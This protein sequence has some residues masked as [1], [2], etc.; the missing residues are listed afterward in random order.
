MFLAALL[1][2][3]IRTL[4]DHDARVDLTLAVHHPMRSYRIYRGECRG[5]ACYHKAKKSPTRSTATHDPDSVL[6]VRD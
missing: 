6:R 3:R 1:T 2:R 5:D 4:L